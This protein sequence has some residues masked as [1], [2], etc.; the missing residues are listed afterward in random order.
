[1]FVNTLVLR[2]DVDQNARFSTLLTQAREVDLNAFANADVPFEQIVEVLRPSR[3]AAY[4]PL[5][6]VMLSFQNLERPKLELAGL[7]VEVLESG[8]T[9]S[10]TDLGVAV[11][12]RFDEGSVANGM[13]AGSPTPPISST[14]RRSAVSPI[15]SSVCWRPSRPTRTPS[16]ATS[17]S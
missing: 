7:T 5:A 13:R 9:T 11:E 6:Q 1:M 2:T 16:S 12:E 10:K 8:L 3:T 15:V 17:T 14:R 4:A